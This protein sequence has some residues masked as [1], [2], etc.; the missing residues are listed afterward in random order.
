MH[1]NVLTAQWSQT[2][3]KSESQSPWREGSASLD[4]GMEVE[5]PAGFR[6][7][8]RGQGPGAKT[9]SSS[10]LFLLKDVIQSNNICPI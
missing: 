7:R 3:K 1:F 8:Y 5:P 10:K 9:P 6:G 4:E 2:V